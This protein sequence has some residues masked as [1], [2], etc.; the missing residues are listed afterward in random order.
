MKNGGK[1]FVFSR[2]LEIQGSERFN[3]G[4]RFWIVGS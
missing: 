1:R 4:E 3:A 2:G